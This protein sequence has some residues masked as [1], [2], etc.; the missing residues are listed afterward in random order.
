MRHFEPNVFHVP[1]RPKIV[2]PP[3]FSKGALSGK[4]ELEFL[5]A[6]ESSIGKGEAGVC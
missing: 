5:V 6:Q 2:A 3:L 1:V 4:I